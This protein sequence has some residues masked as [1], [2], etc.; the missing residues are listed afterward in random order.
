MNA[1]GIGDVLDEIYKHF[2]DKEENEEDGEIIK[3]AIIGKP[4]AR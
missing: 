2:P 1:S 4:N 3:V